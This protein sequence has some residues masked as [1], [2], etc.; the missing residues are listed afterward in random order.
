MSTANADIRGVL[1]TGTDGSLHWQSERVA[2][3]APVEF[4]LGAGGV[5]TIDAAVPRLPLSWSLTAEAD[6]AVLTNAVA[7]QELAD[8]IDSVR[9]ARTETQVVAAPVLTERWAHYAVVAAVARWTLQPVHQ[10][11]LLI[12]RAVAAAGV[13]RDAEAATLF[14]FADDA[15]LD[16]C[17]R[18]LDG[19]MHTAVVD[20]VRAA[21][22]AAE[23]AGIRGAWRP[24]AAE[25]ESLTTLDDAVI[26]EQLTQWQQAD[27][28]ATAP[29]RAGVMNAEIE[30]ETR[31]SALVDIRSVP[32]RILAWSGAN[33][34]E[35]LIE[36]DSAQDVFVVTAFLASGA[37]PRC[38][39]VR[40]M[41]AYAAERES[42]ALVAT[43]PLRLDGGS[44]VAALPADGH[45]LAG[46]S[47]GVLEADTDVRALRT[48][49]LGRRLAELDRT[50]VEAWGL[51]RSAQAALYTV[52]ATALEQ[53]LRE[54]QAE[55]RAQLRIARNMLSGARRRLERELSRYSTD[56]NVADPLAVLLRARIDA[57]GRYLGADQFDGTFDPLLTDLLPP[58]T[59]E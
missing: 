50:V 45:R 2:A 4:A 30:D 41:L 37:D 23:H 44:L 58:E 19:E 5:A 36:H 9:Q 43:A 28:P 42:G 51:H 27:S 53:L 24:Y 13:G 3:I 39:E 56:G 31:D 38:R 22:Q 20:L 21:V 35:L 10:G 1:R 12:D 54:A 16:L 34:P 32:P 29:G 49:P 15:L 8:V 48:D 18:C 57:V 40:R 46:L 33:E 47:F 11:A 14:I 55:H 59:D 7:G 52:S 26:H 6:P 25:L 17:L